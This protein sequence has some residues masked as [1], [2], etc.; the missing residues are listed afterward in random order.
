MCSN[1]RLPM[2]QKKAGAWIKSLEDLFQDATSILEF[3]IFRNA[4]SWK[5][6]LLFNL[7]LFYLQMDMRRSL[8]NK[9]YLLFKRIVVAA[10]AQSLCPTVCDPMDCSTPG[11]SVHGI[12]Q[13]RILVGCHFLL[14][15]IFLTQ[16]LNPHLLCLLIGKWILYHWSH[17]EQKPMNFSLKHH[18]V[19]T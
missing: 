16:G 15:G 10:A 9:N 5:T 14:Q 13:A 3:I 2:Q 6:L 1:S 4:F 8:C 12:F 19:N 7:I 18:T 11:S 17:L